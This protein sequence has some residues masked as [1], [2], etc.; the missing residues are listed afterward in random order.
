MTFTTI[1]F[2]VFMAVTFV[3]YY[4]MPGK[5]QWIILLFANGYFYYQTGWKSALFL[6][7]VV[8]VS[9]AFGLLI[10]K[11][12]QKRYAVAGTVILFVL[13]L[14]VMRMPFAS[15]IMPLG[16]SFYTLQCIGYCIEVHRQTL[17]AMSLIHI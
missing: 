5:F 1:E 15:M 13:L 4:L 9:Y 3:I 17:T 7:A 14:C 10:E 8:L 2:A 6:L 16:L 12:G 11:T